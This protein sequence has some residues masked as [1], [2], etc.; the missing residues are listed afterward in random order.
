MEYMKIP[1]IVFIAIKRY[2]SEKAAGGIRKVGRGTMKRRDRALNRQQ[3]RA[4]TRP[5]FD[6]FR[7][8]CKKSENN[9]FQ[10]WYEFTG[11]IAT[12]ALHVYLFE[13]AVS[14]RTH[15][16]ELRNVQLSRDLFVSRESLP[17]R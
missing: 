8:S 7:F 16:L 9:L 11:W 15:L 5:F 17:L 4:A 10:M 1:L 6:F 3:Q 2:P 13:S 14:I 12:F